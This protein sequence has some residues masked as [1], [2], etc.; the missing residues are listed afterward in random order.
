MGLTV[1]FRP[2][3]SVVLFH[4][5]RRNHYI[6]LDVVPITQFENSYVN[7]FFLPSGLNPLICG[8]RIPAAL[9]E[10]RGTT[11]LVI[12]A[13]DRCRNLRYF[14]QFCEAES[15]WR[16]SLVWSSFAIVFTALNHLD[17]VE[18]DLQSV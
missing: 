6:I 12:E 11:Q 3:K 13:R 9:E 2:I 16:I 8:C 4:I 7:F 1:V 15:G 17:A 18:A 10:G 14:M 5:N